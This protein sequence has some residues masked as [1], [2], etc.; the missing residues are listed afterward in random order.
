MRSTNEINFSII[1]ADIL[2][3]LLIETIEAEAFDEG[4]GA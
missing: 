1:F 2:M 4:V 3:F